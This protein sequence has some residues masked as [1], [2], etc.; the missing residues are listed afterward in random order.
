[1]TFTLFFI[2]WAIGLIGLPFFSVVFVLMDFA[3]KRYDSRGR[4]SMPLLR[5]YCFFL[6]YLSCEIGGLILAFAIWLIAGLPMGKGSGKFMAMNAWL[7]GWW[8]HALL[9]G[10]IRIFSM[11]LEVQNSQCLIPGPIILMVRHSSTADT[12]LAAVLAGK[13]HGLLLRYVLKSEL[14]WDPCLDVVGNR[15]PNV[16]IDRSGR[17][18]QK[19]LEKIKQLTKGLTRTDGILLYPEGTRFHPDKLKKALDRLQESGETVLFE[20]AS[21]MRYVLPPKPGGFLTVLQN[22]E[23]V[24]VAFCVHTGFEGA[25]NFSKFFNG[26]LIGQ[27]IQVKFWRV[28]RKEV[29]KDSQN[30]M[31]WLYG[32]WLLM[33]QWLA[34]SLAANLETR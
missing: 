15:L 28:P 33:D 1:L 20:K 2:L 31:E 13:F 18:T 10:A 14:L 9:F 29:P 23:A 16:F 6:L 3:R 34:K 12:V 27:T 21:G 8:S 11:H 32:Q 7:Q 22:T 30:Q 19:E 26:E 25:E 4:K 24:D 5:A 17:E